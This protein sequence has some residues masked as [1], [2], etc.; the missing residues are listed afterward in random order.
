MNLTPLTTP[1][2][3][4]DRTPYSLDIPQALITAGFAVISGFLLYLLKCWIDE[5]WLKYRRRYRELRAEIAYILIVYA[6]VYAYIVDAP[7]EWHEGASKEIRKTAARMGAFAIERPR[8]CP[9][10]LDAKNLSN[11]SGELIGLSNRM[12]SKN[13]KYQMMDENLDCV[14]KIKSLLKL[15]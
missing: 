15:K 12:Y 7:D 2:P 6:N 10:V 14:K 1:I 4:I 11:V 5:G 9:G 3:T 13:S 8:F